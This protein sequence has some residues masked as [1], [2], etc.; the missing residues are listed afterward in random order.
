MEVMIR[1]KGKVKLDPSDFKAGGEAKVWIIRDK[2]YKIYHEIKHMVPES[3]LMELQ[4]LKSPNIVKP[5][6]IILDNK[7][8]PIGF[9]MTK[10]NGVPLVTIYTTGYQNDKGINNKHLVDLT[11]A[12][13]LTIQ[14]THHQNFLMVDI[15][16][17]NIIV[18]TDWVTPQF[19]DT[20]AWKTPSFPASAINPNVRD[21]SSKTFTE[22]TDW[23]SFAI[24]SCYLFTGIHPFRGSHKKYKRGDIVQ[25]MK[26]HVSIFNADVNLPKAVRD[27]NM[28]PDHYLKWYKLLFENGK[29]IEPPLLPGV[30]G[31]VSVVVTV[32]KSTN[33]FEIT[34]IHEFP[35]EIIFHKTIYGREVTRT[36]QDIWINKTNYHVNDG[37]EAIITPRNLHV[38]LVKIENG[39]LQ[40]KC[41]DSMRSMNY[42]EMSADSKMIIGNTLYLINNEEILEIGFHDMQANTLVSIDSSWSIMTNAEI[43]NGVICQLIM[44]KS[45]I[46]IPVPREGDTSLYIEKEIPELDGYKMVNGKH[47]DGVLILTGFKDSKYD[48][49]ILRFDATYQ[50]YHCRKVNDVDITTP[51]FIVLDNGQTIFINAVDDMELFIRNPKS[52]TVVDIVDPDI[53]STMRLCKNGMQVRFFQGNKLYSIRK[54]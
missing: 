46:I 26:D 9:T 40:L 53:N 8:R 37:V 2:V 48:L 19:I 14:S 33:N 42:T 6:D 15:N 18:A 27:F 20:N 35:D 50:S 13:K 41:L 1:G 52:T 22:L 10:A 32:V 23:Y 5:E 25:R 24:I 3:K 39:L 31:S 36:K 47:R 34:F 7:D 30:T 21:Y 17:L 43:F 29:R 16:E 4:S 38:I 12:M 11:E 44:G 51:N 28:I 45:Y 54:K 49:F